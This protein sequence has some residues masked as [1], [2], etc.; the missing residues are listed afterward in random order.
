VTAHKRLGGGV[1]VSRGSRFITLSDNAFRRLTEF[2]QDRAHIQHY[3]RAYC[4]SCEVP[5]RC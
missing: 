5:A 4:G 3:P 1:A 2:V